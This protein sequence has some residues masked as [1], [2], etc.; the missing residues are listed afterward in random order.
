MTYRD[1]SLEFLRAAMRLQDEHGSAIIAAHICYAIELLE[2]GA[3][4]AS[5]PVPGPLLH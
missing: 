4:E 2:E 1:Q 5:S 3:A